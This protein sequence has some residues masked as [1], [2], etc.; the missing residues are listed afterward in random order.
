MKAIYKTV[1]LKISGES[2]A[3]NVDRTILDHN[4]LN[5]IAKIVAK[6]SALG[7][8][9]GVVVG[10]GNIWRGKLAE[11]V[12]IEQATGDYMG[13]LGTVINAMALQS[14]FE[15]Q[16]LDTRVMSSISIPQVCEAYIRRKAIHHLEEGRVVIFGGG[17]GNP[18]FTTDTTA[19]LRALEIGAD[20]ILMGKNGVE[21]VLDSD[22]RVNK[23][24]KLIEKLSYHELVAKQLGVMD[25]TAAAMLEKSDI[26]THVFN[27]ADEENLIKVLCGE[28]I[29]SII[30]KE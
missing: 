29:G 15:R 14:A 27:M 16:G 20:A 6:I 26:I 22:P 18:F 1:I 21:G 9:V 17:T 13:M 8:Q 23:D 11:S 5:G 19:T 12:G 25:L 10:A 7:I 28:K 24:A 30:T 3:D 4:K 2:L